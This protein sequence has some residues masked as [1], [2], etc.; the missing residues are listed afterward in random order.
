MLISKLKNNTFGILLYIILF[1]TLIY[2]YSNKMVN[3][4]LNRKHIK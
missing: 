4:Q 3:E 1:I 2:V